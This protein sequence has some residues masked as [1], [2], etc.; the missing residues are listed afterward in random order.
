MSRNRVTVQRSDESISHHI[1]HH[2]AYLMVDKDKKAE[3]VE[4]WRVIRL[5]DKRIVSRGKND[6]HFDDVWRLKVSGGVGGIP[7]LQMRT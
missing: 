3:W 4:K 2:E 7:V 1:T 6:T 5:L